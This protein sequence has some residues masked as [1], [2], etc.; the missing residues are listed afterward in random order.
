MTNKLQKIISTFLI[1]L[2]VAGGF[3]ALLAII[4]LNQPAVYWQTAS[5]LFLYLLAMIVF[6][7]DLHFKKRGS[8]RRARA[9]HRDTAPAFQRGARIVSSALW[10]RFE[11]LRSWSYLRQWLH[12]LL[13]PGFIFWATVSLFYS[14]NL[15]LLSSSRYWSTQQTILW[16]SALALVGYYW[17]LKEIFYR[18]KEIVD[19]DIFVILTT[20][21]I[22]AAAV[23][24]AAAL[25]MLRYN[26]LSPLYFSLEVLCYTFL[27]I[28]QALY[29]H[30]RINQ[31]TIAVT[32]IIAFL[33][34]LIGQLVYMYWGFDYFTAAIFMTA[35]YNLFWGVFHYRLDRALTKQ[36]FLEI[37]MIS[38]LIAAMVISTTN[39]KARIGDGCDYRTGQVR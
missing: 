17:Y 35:C 23:L 10:D 30:R 39:F 28:Y 32:V 33:M 9:R 37:L 3:E 18:R 29:Q 11:H 34:G 4:N 20:I 7:F 15:I 19:S 27:L 38:V 12:F 31:Y 2:A 22:Y 14:N 26:C 1:A 8:W 25:S 36:A 24:F 6:L 21:K 5:W 16:L 13:L